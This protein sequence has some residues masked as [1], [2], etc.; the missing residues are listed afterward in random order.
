MKQLFFIILIILSSLTA[1]DEKPKNPVA[2]VG[3]NLINSFK[4]GREA[5]A[6]ANL[7]ALKMAIQV[8]Y[9]ENDKYPEN[10]DEL[11]D[12]VKSSSEIDF[13]G[14]DYDTE[15]GRISINNGSGG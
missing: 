3:D 8:Y 4:K 9:A 5:G 15:T 6:I 14:F 1:C 2:D 12:L 10:L 13:S 11:S 7:H